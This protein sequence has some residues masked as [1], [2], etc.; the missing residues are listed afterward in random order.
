MNDLEYIADLVA[1]F[2]DEYMR[3]P[4]LSELYMFGGPSNCYKLLPCG[5]PDWLKTLGYD[6]EDIKGRKT[7]EVLDGD[8]LIFYDTPSRVAEE[9]NINISTISVALGRG[10]DLRNGYTLRVKEVK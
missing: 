5:Y 2:Y 1:E 4:T 8:E 6:D 3:T 9:L 7:I 10:G